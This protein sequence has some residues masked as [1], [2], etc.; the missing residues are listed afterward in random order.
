MC[1][2]PYDR[3]KDAIVAPVRFEI[4]PER[5]LGVGARTAFSSPAEAAD[6]LVKRGLR[7]TLQSESLITGQQMVALDFIANA[8][9]ASVTM[10]G[11]D[12]VLPTAEGGGFA[13]LQASA[14]D[15]L[16]KVNTIPFA[17]IGQNLDGILKAV[18]TLTNGPQL[19][20]ALTDASTTMASAADLVR[21]VDSGV[22]P[23]TR[24]LPDIATKLQSSL[25]N[26]NKLMLSLDGGYGDNTKFNRDLERLLVQLNDAVRSIRSLA[27]LLTRHPEALIKGRPEGGVE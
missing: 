3:A 10:A 13:G 15:L 22:T 6:V 19:R 5:I 20:Q 4:D 18:N 27:D 23:A 12:F 24:Q 8:P 7:A 11:S 16:D 14:S 26:V 1:S 2:S 17:Q 9:P 25:T 21:H